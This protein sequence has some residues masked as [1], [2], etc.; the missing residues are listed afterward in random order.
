MEQSFPQGAQ[1]RSLNPCSAVE[2]NAL[3]ISNALRKK[4][5]V[6][7]HYILHRFGPAW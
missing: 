3:L 1:L 6:F 2:K 5:A 4:L 7:L